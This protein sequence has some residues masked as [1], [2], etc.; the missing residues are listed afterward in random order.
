MPLS[1]ANSSVLASVMW[2]YRLQRR[3]S[4]SSGL[5][6]VGTSVSSGLGQVEPEAPGLTL[7]PGTSG[8]CWWGSE[9]GQGL[10]LMQ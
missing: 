2:A 9:G 8:C 1:A 10:K 5:V 3:P 4:D 6:T 7:A